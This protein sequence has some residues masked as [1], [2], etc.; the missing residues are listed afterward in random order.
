M[1]RDQFFNERR[2]SQVMEE[3]PCKIRFPLFYQA[4]KQV[5]TINPGQKL[6]IPFGWFHLVYSEGDE[7]N[8]AM[9]YFIQNGSVEAEGAPS[10]EEPRVEPSEL[11]DIDPLTIFKKN[12]KIRIIHTK[13]GVFPTDYLKE[14]FKNDYELKDK[15]IQEFMDDKDHADYIMQWKTNIKG[16]T[17]WLNWGNVRTHLHYDTAS[18]W[19]HQIKG[20]K[21]AILFP[22]DDR[23][24][25]YMWNSYPIKLVYQLA[26]DYN[27]TLRRNEVPED[28][29]QD[30][31]RRMGVKT[32]L[33][34]PNNRLAARNIEEVQ[35]DLAYYELW[36]MV[37]T[38]LT[39]QDKMYNLHAGDYIRLPNHECYPWGIHNQTI[40][41]VQLSG[42]E[43]PLPTTPEN[44]EFHE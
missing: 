2:Y 40:F 3:F 29:V 32:S 35:L 27:V 7:F 8:F 15:T 28:A 37:D 23:D 11:G 12:E 5:F 25:L 1:D 24:L 13:S 14:R 33:S 16:A 30:I 4:R 42:R 36:F 19:L 39:I 44:T 10:S 26:Q 18:N 17:A 43:D 9:N 31:I 6:Y 34:L 41:V 20:R 22:P 21:R 38:V